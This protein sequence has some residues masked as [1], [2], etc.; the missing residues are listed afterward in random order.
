MK[1]TQKQ[2]LNLA[3]LQQHSLKQVDWPHQ[4]SLQ[5]DNCCVFITTKIMPTAE[6]PAANKTTNKKFKPTAKSP[7]QQ[8]H[9]Q[10]TQAN[11][12]NATT[13]STMIPPPTQ[14]Q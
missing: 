7:L 10:I 2:K 8:Q 3:C 13:T 11:N 9:Q 12:N 14:L 5:S 4:L 6:L 1:H